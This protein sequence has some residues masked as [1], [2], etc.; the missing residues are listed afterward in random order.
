MV[1]VMKIMVTSFTRSCAHTVRVSAPYYASDHC[2]P[3]GPLETPRH[4]WASLGLSLV[5]SLF[6]SSG[7]WYAWDSVC[8]LQEAISQSCVSS[9]GSMVG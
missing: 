3:T 7:A 4:S 2:R 6:L 5:G 9:G 8:A 1:A